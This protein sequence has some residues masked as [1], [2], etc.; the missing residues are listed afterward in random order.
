MVGGL[1]TAACGTILS[2]AWNATWAVIFASGMRGVMAGLVAGALV[3]A[4]S[5]FYHVEGPSSEGSPSDKRQALLANSKHLSASPPA[6]HSPLKDKME[7]ARRRRF[8]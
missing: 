3:G 7:A 4:I 5:G 8:S 2:L 6:L 1:F